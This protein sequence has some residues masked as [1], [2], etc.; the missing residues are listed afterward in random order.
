MIFTATFMQLV[1]L[2]IIIFYV[3]ASI[4]SR[5]GLALISGLN[6]LIILTLILSGTSELSI[7]EFITFS[8]LFAGIE[9]YSVFEL[10]RAEI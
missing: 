9:I 1:I 5:I 4:S 10:R 7:I 6:L 8:I 3:T 2:F